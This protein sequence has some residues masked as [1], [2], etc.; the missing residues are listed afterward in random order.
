MSLFQ[1]IFNSALGKTLLYAFYPRLDGFQDAKN[2][3]VSYD[4]TTRKMTFTHASGTVTLWHKGLRY[5][6]ASPYT[7]DVAHTNTKG[8]YWLGFKDSGAPEWD[9]TPFDLENVSPMAFAH[10]DP[11]AGVYFGLREAHGFMDAETHLEL[12]EKMGTYRRSGGLL[13]AGTY[14]VQT[15]S[16]AAITPGTD[17]VVVADEDCYTSIAA[18]T[19]G[20]YTRLHFISGEPVFTAASALP[21]PYTGNSPQYNP[22]GTSLSTITTSNTYFNLYVVYMPVTSDA[23][24]QK[25]RA[26]WLIGQSTYT[27]TSTAQAEDFRSLNLGTFSDMAPEFIPFVQITFRF[28]TGYGGT[29]RTRIEANPFYI[30]G[31]RSSLVTLSGLTPSTHNNLSGREDPACH[32][33][34]AIEV[35]ATTG[36]TVTDLQSYIDGRYPG[37]VDFIAEVTGSAKTTFTLTD[38]NLDATYAID[39]DIDGRNQPIEGTQ[40]TRVN[41]NPGQ[42]VMS[43]AVN[44]GSTFKCRVYSK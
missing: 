19:Q 10:Y 16:D 13:T 15:S 7:P 36:R 34:A 42:I 12:H 25:Y 26:L 44:V 30:T 37:F 17:S 29:T 24:S 5:Q 2:V 21:L 20:S 32:P 35:A 8:E 1:K 41:A 31:T 3:G 4:Y 18:V 23:E 6:F 22:T 28:N 39:V 11:T 9:S 27:S 38:F 43:E 33:A 40:W 14:T